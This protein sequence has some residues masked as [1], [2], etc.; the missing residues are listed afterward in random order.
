MSEESHPRNSEVRR[1]V[2]LDGLSGS[3]KSTLARHLAGELGWAYL[4][5]GA[6]Y[7]AL[8]WATLHEGADPTESGQVLDVLS[9]LTLSSALAGEVIVD[10]L[11]LGQELRTPAIDAKVSEVADHPEVRMALTERMQQIRDQAGIQGVVADGRDAGA[12]IFPDAALKIFVEASLE[13]RAERRHSQQQA[14]GMLTTLDQA[15]AALAARDARDA[16]RGEAA[17][18]IHSGDQVLQNEN[19]SVEEAI[20]RLLVWAQAIFGSGHTAF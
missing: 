8:T 17:P 2:T 12:V 11:R 13:V 16:A 4:D 15:R 19:L 5:S 6:W 10:G 3:G 1:V 20:R 14:A 9:R 18:Q 7:R